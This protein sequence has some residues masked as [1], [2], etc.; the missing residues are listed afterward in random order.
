[1]TNYI[2]CYSGSICS[3]SQLI[4]CP[5]NYEVGPLFFSSQD[6]GFLNCLGNEIIRN[7]AGQYIFYYRIDEKRT[8]INIYSESKKK[9]F[10]PPVKIFA[11]VE[12]HEPVQ[13]F[14]QFRMDEIKKV[15][16]YF[17]KFNLQKINLKPTPGDFI[18]FGNFI[19]EINTVIELQPIYGIPDD[20][21]Q[22]KAEC[23]TAR[24]NI[25]DGE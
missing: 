5:D 15:S 9:V 23:S 14:T 6:L 11:R 8:P 12:F 18:K 22:V 19:L 7:V 20:M 13:T 21:L 4:N 24:E 25:F 10:F 2:S 17:D 3:G 16:V 1:M